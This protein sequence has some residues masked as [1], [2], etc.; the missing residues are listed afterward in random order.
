MET[1]SR[2]ARLGDRH[3]RRR[4]PALFEAN[5]KKIKKYRA[6]QGDPKLCAVLFRSIY[7]FFANGEGRANG[8][9]KWQRAF[10]FSSDGARPQKAT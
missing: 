3:P 2:R 7:S 6:R 9:K 8:F 1:P 5:E 4:D 10:H